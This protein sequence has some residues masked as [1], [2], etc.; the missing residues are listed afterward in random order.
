M[1][2]RVLNIVLCVV[3]IVLMVALPLRNLAW[4]DI[5]STARGEAAI[6][7]SYVML[8]LFGSLTVLFGVRA[9]KG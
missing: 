1:K 6:L 7:A 3:S 8:F 4:V 9:A 5:P 2:K